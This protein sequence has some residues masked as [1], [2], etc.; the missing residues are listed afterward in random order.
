MNEAEF[1]MERIQK[2][3]DD[4]YWT[5]YV[6]DFCNY[7]NVL[8][9]GIERYR[10]VFIQNFLAHDYE[11]DLLEIWKPHVEHYRKAN[12]VLG[13]FNDIYHG[14]VRDIDEIIHRRYEQILWFHGP[15]HLEKHELFS[16]FKKLHK[17]CTGLLAMAC[18]YGESES[19][20][21]G[22]NEH[23]RHYS[24]LYPD[25]FREWGFDVVQ[26]DKKRIKVWTHV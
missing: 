24:A 9:I 20:A 22:G 8:Y 11:I 10:C 3:W 19:P 13:F 21:R 2:T 1:V 16:V 17:M 12:K 25:F 14:D 6:P 23:N 18:P 15:E 7:K 5:D 26:E 4:E